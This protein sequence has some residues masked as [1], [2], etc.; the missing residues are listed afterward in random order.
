M[1]LK[2]LAVSD[3]T[4][5]KEILKLFKR[6]GGEIAQS[7]VEKIRRQNAVSFKTIHLTMSD[8]QLIALRV[9]DT[10]DIYQV[11]LNGK[12]LPIK[13]QDDEKN[14]VTEI[15]NAWQSNVSKFQAALSRK[16]AQ[17]PKGIQSTRKKIIETLQTQIAELDELIK[18]QEL[19][20]GI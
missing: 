19:K 6:A 4:A 5:P 18:E 7:S 9:K 15:V 20:L 2:D 1:I 3:K 8:S 16:K 12:V 13:N 11:L 10:G 14:A 17:L